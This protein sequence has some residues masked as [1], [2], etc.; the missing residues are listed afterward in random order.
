VRQILFQIPIAG[1]VKIYGYG[2]MLVFA[3]LSALAIAKWRAKREKLDSLLVE[4]MA[5]WVILG[6]LVGARAF[7]VLQYWGTRV[8]SIWEIFKIWEG[9]IVL[10]GSI[11]GGTLAFFVFR[12]FKPFPLRPMLDCIAPALALGIAIGRVGC[13]LNGC[14]YGDRCDFPWAAAFPKG[15]MPW[16]AQLAE[17][18][19][20]SD[21][22]KSLPVHPTQIYSTID[23]LILLFLLSTYYPLRRRDGEVMALLMIAYPITRFLIERLRN[24]EKAIA[25]GMTVSQNISILL[26]ILGIVNWLVLQRWPKGRYADSAG[27]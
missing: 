7:F 25:F 8:S 10:Y 3:F 14:C 15:S 12:W 1:G 11:M 13:F 22:A 5:I 19:I 4:D 26:V 2:L 18:L 23:G 6:G 20:T 17:G 24:D 16:Q 9:G 21:A 27:S